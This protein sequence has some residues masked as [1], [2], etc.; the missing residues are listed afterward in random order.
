MHC[1]DKGHLH[2]AVMRNGCAMTE[3]SGSQWCARYPTSNSVDDLEPA[4]RAKVC[5]F[6][7]A[8]KLGGATVSISATLRPPERAYLMQGA[9][10]IINGLPSNMCWKGVTPN[11]P[12]SPSK[13]PPLAGVDIDWTHRGD[14]A[15]ATKAAKEM[16]SRYGIVYAPSRTSLHIRGLAIDMTITFPR[17][18]TL[19][20]KR[21]APWTIPAGAIGSE[22]QKIKEVGAGFGVR[23][24]AS[25]KPHWSYNGR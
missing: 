22:S 9:W 4:F 5:D 10:A 13:I 20:D 21:G 1:L 8:L 24:L 19:V 17:G 11:T 6:L 12:V 7:H 16:I 15:A 25:D 14:T 2:F 18:G 3:E 23:K